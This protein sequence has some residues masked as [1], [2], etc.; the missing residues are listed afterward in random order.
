MRKILVLLLPFFLMTACL[1]QDFATQEELKKIEQEVQ[2]CIDKNY[3]TDYS[4]MQCTNKGTKKYNNEINRTVKTAKNHLSNAQYE[5]FLKAQAS[6][7]N[8]MT[9][10]DKLLKQTYEKKCPPYL[11]CLSAAD[12]RYEYTKSRA[13]DLSGFLGTLLLFKEDGVLDDE[14]NFVPFGN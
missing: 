10:N 11:P 12:D 8:F 3:M 13:M 6:W 5:Q 4:M 2:E 9:E 1:A 7:Q 14:L